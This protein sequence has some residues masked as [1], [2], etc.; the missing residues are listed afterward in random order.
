MGAD[1]AFLVES[2]VHACNG[3]P[4]VPSTHMHPDSDSSSTKPV[5]VLVH[6]GR[7]SVRVFMSVADL[8]ASIREVHRELGHC[9]VRATCLRV[10]ERVSV[11]GLKGH[12]QTVLDECR[13]CPYVKPVT[14]GEVKWGTVAGKSVSDVVS[15]DLMP[16]L[17]CT[18]SGFCHILHIQNQYSRYSFLVPLRTKLSEEVATAF[19]S[20]YLSVF[21]VPRAVKHDQGS[22][23]KGEFLQLLRSRGMV[24]L[25]SPVNNPQSNG[26]LERRNAE[27]AVIVK[28]LLSEHGR[29][30]NEWDSVLHEAQTQLNRRPVFFGKCGKSAYERQLGSLPFVP[31]LHFLSSLADV[32]PKADK[33]VGKKDFKPGDRVIYKPSKMYFRKF[34]LDCWF[35]YVV[36]SVVSPG[37]IYKVHRAPEFVP[38]QSGPQPPEEAVASVNCLRLDV[39]HA[40]S[41][42]GRVE[43]SDRH[44]LADV[45]PASDGT[46]APQPAPEAVGEP[47][48]VQVVQDLDKD[49]MIV[50]KDASQGRLFVAKAVSPVN[51]DTQLVDVRVYGSGSVGPLAR[52]VFAPSWRLRGD[53]PMVS[54]SPYKQA[55]ADPEVVS[56]HIGSVV[57]RHVTLDKGRLPAE[58][59]SQ[60]REGVGE[61]AFLG[62]S[63]GSNGLVAMAGATVAETTHQK[64]RW[65]DLT[66]AERVEAEAARQAELDKFV[67]YKAYEPVARSSLPAGAKCIP[68][69]WVE[70]MKLKNGVRV[71][72]ARLVA[73]GNRDPRDRAGLDTRSATCKHDVLRFC[74][75]ASMQDAD[76]DPEQMVQIDVTSA[77]LQAP[78]LS[79]EPVYVLPPKGSPDYKSGKVWLVKQAIYGLADAGK[80]F[81]IYRDKKLVSLGYEKT[82]VPSVWLKRGAGG[83]IL[84]CLCAYVDDFA[85]LPRGG[86]VA[87]IYTLEIGRVLDCSDPQPLSLYVGVDFRVCRD[88]VFVS[89][90]RYVSSLCVPD[91]QAPRQ[92]LPA[93]A[94]EETDNSCVLDAADT[95]KFRSLL[96]ALAYVAQQTRPDLAYACSFLGQW[97]AAPTERALRLLYGVVRYAKSTCMYGLRIP[98]P[99]HGVCVAFEVHAD[100]SFGNLHN[101]VQQSARS[102]CGYVLMFC[103]VPIAWRSWKLDKV[104]R[105][106]VASEMYALDD[107]VDYILSLLPLLR[108]LFGVSVRFDLY[109]DAADLLALL[110]QDHPKPKQ[111]ALTHVVSELKEKSA[112][113]YA[114]ALNDDLHDHRLGPVHKI[115]THLN[116]ADLLTKPLPTDALLSRMCRMS[117]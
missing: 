97:S 86:K 108:D 117:V 82:C 7:K 71:F 70:S 102:Q 92:P 45:A 63:A 12:V 34:E 5:S 62:T 89:Q 60:L 115:A 15:V 1:A 78:L 110:A 104:S 114:L 81:E 26:M 61:C 100:A 36:V 24:S 41:A 84:C 2:S 14:G 69:N 88:S 46:A 59:V 107:C 30:E 10:S 35:P 93:K 23:F 44:G 28:A 98:R 79:K 13:V 111:R 72:K 66:P 27:V 43:P 75:I 101:L 42:S 56:V 65:K 77:Y 16:D 37:S 9:G 96:G 4:S 116:V 49:E 85:L 99:A 113:L 31:S 47:V 95:T 91:G 20:V 58:L 18:A 25:M 109:S 51:K 83:R 53:V 48:S 64:F 90:S 80:A 21:G 29:E 106:T 40:A 54:F 38:R 87:R 8:H 22:E 105:S 94:A 50:F 112:V 17:P 33:T 19:A 32:K 39:K 11:P 76:F 73:C 68:L 57:A 6:K 52:R 67:R 74:L 103:G 3:S 55:N